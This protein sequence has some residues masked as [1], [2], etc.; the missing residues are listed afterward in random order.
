MKYP[1]LEG[2]KDP[3]LDVFGRELLPEPEQIGLQV[4]LES[5]HVGLASFAPGGFLEGLI[6]VLKR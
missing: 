6:Q 5:S 1:L 2:L 3:N 4:E